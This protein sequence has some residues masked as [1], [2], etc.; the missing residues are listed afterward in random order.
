MAQSS[1]TELQSQLLIARDVGHLEEKQFNRLSE[2]TVSTHKLVNGLLSA[3]R[4]R[5]EG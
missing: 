2:Q 4:K 5:S 3:T 1:V